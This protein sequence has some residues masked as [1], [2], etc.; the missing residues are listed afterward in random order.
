MEIFFT[1]NQK[2]TIVERN[3]LLWLIQNHLFV[4]S[5]RPFCI[6][7]M[8]SC[9]T[10]SKNVSNMGLI[11]R[12]CIS[13]KESVWNTSRDG[14]LLMPVVLVVISDLFISEHSFYYSNFHLFS[15][16]LPAKSVFPAVPFYVSFHKI[17]SVRYF[18]WELSPNCA[19]NIKWI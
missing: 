8:L 4:I 17:R 10:P 9:H 6:S 15:D 11:E 16:I 7:D 12:S 3:T 19:S 1:G 5:T 13:F 18:L 14:F 2:N